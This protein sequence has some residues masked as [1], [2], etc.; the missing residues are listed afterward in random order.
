ML[1]PKANS[2]VKKYVLCVSV[3]I[4]CLPLGWN[5]AV[6]NIASMIIFVLI[7]ALNTS[8]VLFFR[9]F[10]VALYL[11]LHTMVSVQ[12]RELE[13]SFFQVLRTGLPFLLT[14]LIPVA[15]KGTELSEK[16]KS[17][18]AY[19]IVFL[20]LVNYIFTVSGI[21][22]ASVAIQK[23]TEEGSR[24]YL[25]PFTFYMALLYYF[26]S[27]KK[28]IGVICASFLML[29]TGGRT[30]IAILIA[31][32]LMSRGFSAKSV[33][34]GI[35]GAFVSLALLVVVMPD[36]LMKFMLLTNDQRFWEVS[37][38]LS[39]WTSSIDITILGVGFGVPVSEGYFAFGTGREEV[40]RQMINST[41][42]VHNLIPLLLVR[43]G[44]VGLCV[45]IGL[46]LFDTRKMASQLP[47][48]IVLFLFGL[49][50]AAI[51]TTPDGCFFVLLWYL[52]MS[53]KNCAEK[54]RSE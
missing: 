21:P 30:Q 32:I 9:L 35:V 4:L 26:S 19:G 6:W 10:G 51:L 47:Y 31:I 50:A 11:L 16:E 24:I 33:L 20:G 53:G 13:F 48:L 42:D 25:I 17:S 18:L 29:V 39:L 23:V 38:A 7:L 45:V 46:L 3:V 34:Y 22:L 54:N 1:T 49:S 12:F 27:N 15:V 14:L 40:S 5:V 8:V 37:Q 43:T 44:I 2:S 52:L 28:Y 41:F 36:V